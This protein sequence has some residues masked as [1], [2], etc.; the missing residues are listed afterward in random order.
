MGCGSSTSNRLHVLS[1]VVKL[2]NK[3][4]NIEVI[5]EMLAQYSEPLFT[6]ALTSARLKGAVRRFNYVTNSDTMAES[7]DNSIQHMMS[8]FSLSCKGDWGVLNLNVSSEAPYISLDRT[9][10][11]HEFKIII[12]AWDVLISELQ[13]LHGIISSLKHNV[14]S[15]NDQIDG[16][17]DRVES[18]LMNTVL[19]SKETGN[20]KKLVNRKIESM[21]KA[22]ENVKNLE[23]F[24]NRITE[25]A[26]KIPDIKNNEEVLETGRTFDGNALQFMQSMN[27]N[28]KVE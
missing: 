8:C 12:E 15:L 6:L 7:I 20:V 10:L 2:D 14:D 25:E 11:F 1:H 27:K 3:P 21:K 13:Q 4:T 23:A 26:S 22:S 28:K 19:S 9:Q 18:V 5:D 16:I 24:M 17:N